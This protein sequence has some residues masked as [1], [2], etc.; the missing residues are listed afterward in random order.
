[1]NRLVSMTVN[2]EARELAVV[3]N[4]TLLDALRNEG[5]LTGTKKGCDVGDCGACTVIMD[6]RP[7]NACLVLAIEAEGAT[8]ETIEGLQPAYDQPHLL[9]Q[10]FMEHG[11]A[12]C[13]FC[14]PGI[15]M[16]A[17]ALLDENPDPSEDEIRFALAG[18]ICRCTG[19]TKIIDAVRATAE[20][21][22]K[23]GTL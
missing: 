22:R 2:G 17:K 6:G 12:Q 13:G 21:L 19:Y 8:I 5:S 23:A 11:G 18:N 1:M 10:K 9:Q 20:E 3:P 16:M 14:T 4:R 7:V 15:I